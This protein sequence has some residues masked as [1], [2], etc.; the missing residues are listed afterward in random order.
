MPQKNDQEE[1][2][3]NSLKTILLKQDL[4]SH[5]DL[6]K[7]LASELKI[8]V[9]E[10]AA[11]LTLVNYPDLFP[12]KQ[13]QEKHQTNNKI[14]DLPQGLAKQKIVRY[15][16]DIGRKH[17]VTLEQIKNVLVEVSG[18][19]RDKIGWVDIRNYY[20]LIELPDGMPADIFQLLTEVEVNNQKLNLKRVKLQR[21]F[22][23]RNSKKKFAQQS[24][25][26]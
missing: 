1:D 25:K 21:R 18:V 19:E 24:N 20:T 5:Q 14:V 17:Q 4:T 12:Q 13:N 11:A 22:Y 9:L 6:I 10:C 8:S 3:I 15:R 16:L 26:E 2:L 23:R 7:R